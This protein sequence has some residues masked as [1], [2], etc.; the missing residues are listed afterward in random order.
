MSINKDHLLDDDF[1]GGIDV[2]KLTDAEKAIYDKLSKPVRDAWLKKTSA[3]AESRKDQESKLS[4]LQQQYDAA[5]KQLADVQAWWQNEGQY[6]TKA[7][8]REV[9]DDAGVEPSALMRELSALKTQFTTAAAKYDSTI[10][11]LSEQ[12]KTL[13][14]MIR[15]QSD[16]FDIRMKHP[17]ADPMRII[18]TAKEKGVTNLDLA[19]QMAYGE[20]KHQAAID[21]AVSEAREEERA[22]VSAEQAIVDT[23]PSTTRYAPPEEAKS[24]ADASKSLLSEVRKT[25]GMPI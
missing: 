1:S 25:G 22:K 19:Y 8:A 17:D 14:N 6:L 24:Y 2:S 9:L 5:A 13:E 20:E 3:L 11:K 15:Y 12:N 23:K 4:Q 16:L 18:E 21:K 10:G 7:E